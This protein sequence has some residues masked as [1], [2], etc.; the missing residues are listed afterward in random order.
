MKTIAITGASS[1]IGRAIA[2]GVDGTGHEL[3]LVGRDV[4]RLEETATGLRSRTRCVQ[5]DLSTLAGARRL[6]DTLAALPRLDVLVH[7]AAVAPTGLHLTADG[8]EEAF[9]VNHL[10]PFVVNDCL[11][12]RFVADGTRLVQLGTALYVLGRV[13]LERG[14]YGG[15][16][17]SRRTLLSS[18]LWN[19]VATIELSRSGVKANVVH[20]GVVNPDRAGFAG[21][22][23]L[24]SRLGARFAVTPAEAAR[25]P[26]ALAI[27][28][29]HEWTSGRYFDGL[30]EARLRGMARRPGI[31]RAVVERTRELVQ[32]GGITTIRTTQ[33]RG[34]LG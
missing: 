8:F 26:V 21:P 1:D 18:K 6:A 11:R 17:Y 5:A 29:E 10:G 15:R 28:P 4:G 9:A 3:V 7:N 33:D 22:L 23:G 30:S 20:P 14:P 27:A 19:L 12:D 16:F 24:F 25:G 31:G 13:D 34:E 2:H 32:A